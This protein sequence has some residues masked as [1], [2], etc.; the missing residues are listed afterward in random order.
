[1]YKKIPKYCLICSYRTQIRTVKHN[2]SC[3]H[4]I[5][6]C[7]RCGDSSHRWENCYGFEWPKRNHYCYRCYLFGV[8][9][10]CRTCQNG[11]PVKTFFGI[12]ILEGNSAQRQSLANQLTEES[13]TTGALNLHTRLL[14]ALDGIL[15]YVSWIVCLVI[16]RA[17]NDCISNKKGL[18]GVKWVLKYIQSKNN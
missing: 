14:E 17:F 9:H 3:P 16:Y 2:G 11:D 1:M 15:W 13:I 6:R 10:D 7:I 12:C 4:T 8:S 5:H 18:P